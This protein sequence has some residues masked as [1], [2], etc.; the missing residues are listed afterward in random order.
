MRD[1]F[2]TYKNTWPIV[3][4]YALRVT[5]EHFVG[6]DAA[7]HIRGAARR[8]A[9]HQTD[10]TLPGLLRNAYRHARSREH[11][12]HDQP[13]QRLCLHGIR[14]SDPFIIHYTMLFIADFSNT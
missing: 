9:N 14:P 8:K 5:L 1:D 4:H 13:T 7:H 10:G 12:S 6:D 11:R 2:R 3:D